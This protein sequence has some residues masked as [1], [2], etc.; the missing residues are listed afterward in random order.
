MATRVPQPRAT[1]AEARVLSRR[2]CLHPKIEGSSEKS[3]PAITQSHPSRRRNKADRTTSG[4]A[5][6]PES[7]ENLARISDELPSHRA[8][9]REVGPGKTL[10][11]CPPL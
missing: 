10:H 3:G 7:R 8:L 5:H 11:S 1:R 6:R 2:S 9:L 4:R